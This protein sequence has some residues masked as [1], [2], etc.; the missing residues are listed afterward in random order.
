MSA[1]EMN[2]TMVFSIFLEGLNPVAGP[3]EEDHEGKEADGSEDV[4]NIGHINDLRL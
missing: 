4:E 1:S 3:H 2:P